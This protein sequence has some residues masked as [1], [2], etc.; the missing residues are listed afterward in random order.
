MG[1]TVI[2]E[3]CNN[4]VGVTVTDEL[5]NN[6]VGV[7]VTDEFNVDIIVGVTLDVVDASLKVC[8]T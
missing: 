5:C 4:E 1:V 2:D 6:E 7:T 8:I 3:L